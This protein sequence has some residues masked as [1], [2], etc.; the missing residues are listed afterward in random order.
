MKYPIKNVWMTIVKTYP[1]VR[2]K[3]LK[4][5]IDFRIGLPLTYTCYT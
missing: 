3:S 4:N 1:A 5:K 2:N